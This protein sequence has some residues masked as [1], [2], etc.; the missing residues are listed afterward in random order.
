MA[1]DVNVKE[2]N[3]NSTTAGNGD[4]SA[5]GAGS[6]VSANVSK[7]SVLVSQD[8]SA[9]V[10]NA[11][12]SGASGKEGN[13]VNA[14]NAG[15]A[16]SSLLSDAKADPKDNSVSDKDVK[17]DDVSSSDNAAAQIDFDKLQVPQGFVFDEALK[18]KVV[19]VLNELNVS[20]KQAQELVD[21]LSQSLAK[22]RAVDMDTYKA[23]V[24]EWVRSVKADPDFGGTKLPE[25]LSLA[26]RAID[27]YAGSVKEAGEL[28]QLLG[29]TGI[30]NHPLLVRFMIRVGQGIA[31][32]KL[33]G[34]SSLD[35][36]EE[37]EAKLAQSLFDKSL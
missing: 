12:A 3:N 14:D 34:G 23:S 5:A 35:S 7:G 18:D 36:G 24:D 9:N 28:R 17:K 6:D 25:N 21:V 33:G 20:Q 22:Q 31:E 11:D 8:T 15:N 16:D 29:E 1:D 37:R 2:T 10:N 30:G 19:P 4:S 13:S 26:A 27:R 32:D